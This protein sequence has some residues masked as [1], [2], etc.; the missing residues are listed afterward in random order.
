MSGR[1]VMSEASI[2]RTNIRNKYNQLYVEK[3]TNERAYQ[4]SLKAEMPELKQFQKGHSKGGQI[5]GIFGSIFWP[6]MLGAGGGLIGI[7]IG[8][9]A[10]LFVGSMGAVMITEGEWGTG[11]MGPGPLLVIGI[12]IVG[13]VI[14]FFAVVSNAKTKKENKKIQQENDAKMRRYNEELQ[15]I[16]SEKEKSN[17][18]IAQE[19][20]KMTDLA[21]AEIKRY[22]EEV[23]AFCQQALG[24]SGITPMA[25]RTVDMFKRMIS[26]QESGSDVKYVEAQFQYKVTKEGI[27]YV[28]GSGYSNPESGFDFKKERFHELGR[29]EECEGLAKALSVL[30]MARMKEDYP[31]DLTTIKVTNQDAAFTMH[32]KTANENF[33]AAKDIF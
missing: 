9:F 33:E 19:R 5:A 23:E 12:Y 26:H 28:Y 29:N 16:S 31:S 8:I 2:I 11:D 10:L 20:K 32:F 21:N 17:Q 13:V 25:D 18:R 1:E 3:E 6:V 15:R 30:V 24:N 4:A 27:S 22:D 14:A 7:G